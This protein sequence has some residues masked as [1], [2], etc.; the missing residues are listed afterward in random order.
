MLIT[1]SSRGHLGLIDLRKKGLLAKADIT[2]QF[3]VIRRVQLPLVSVR[4]P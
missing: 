3:V 2:K 4:V 1:I